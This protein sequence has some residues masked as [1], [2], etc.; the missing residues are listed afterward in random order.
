M[1]N[2]NL[3]WILGAVFG[4][5]ASAGAFAN[6]AELKI[7]EINTAHN[8]FGIAIGGQALL[9]IGMVIC[10]FGLAFGMMEFFKIKN[11][12]AHQCMLDVS[13]IIFETCKTY[14]IQQG[15]F[16]VVLWLLIG[17]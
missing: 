1:R 2:R 14:L 8:I 11:V 12:R 15:K 3:Q 6:E 17:A 13:N 10:L 5:V 16:L 7:P 9:L 4:L